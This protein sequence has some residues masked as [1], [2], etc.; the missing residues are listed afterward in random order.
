LVFFPQIELDM[1]GMRAIQAI[2]PEGHPPGAAFEKTH[3]QPWKL[4]ED[5]VINHARERDNQ[6]QRMAEAVESENGRN[7]TEAEEFYM[8]LILM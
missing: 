8:R 3:P 4:V 6:R 5:T 1:V 7:K 2:H